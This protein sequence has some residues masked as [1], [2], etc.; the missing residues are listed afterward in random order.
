MFV[1]VL[2]M[3]PILRRVGRN[4]SEDRMLP[5]AFVALAAS[6]GLLPMGSHW[7]LLGGLVTTYFLAFNLLEAGMPALLAR[8]T[9]SRGRGRRMGLYSTFQF[10]GAFCGGVAGGWLVGRFGGPF[11]LAAAG[12]LALAWGLLLKLLTQ[13][14]FLT[15]T[16]S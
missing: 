10:L 3:L 1:S 13:R 5:W 16:V 7:L 4:L 2:L 14:F 6:V 11:A 8:L 12:V 9:G 15:G